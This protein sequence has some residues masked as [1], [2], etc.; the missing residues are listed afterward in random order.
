[1]GNI[2]EDPSQKMTGQNHGDN[3]YGCPQE[4]GY[5][6]F[7][8]INFGHSRQDRHKSPNHRQNT[9]EYKGHH[10]M[11]LIKRLRDIYVLLL[12]EET[13]LSIQQIEASPFTG[14]VPDK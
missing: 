6:E 12:E 11:L 13:V 8:E 2:R 10:P 7:N 9:P 3:P 1:M 5:Q 4:I 14:Q